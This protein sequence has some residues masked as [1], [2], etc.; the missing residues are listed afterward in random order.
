[1]G[2][3]QNL[4]NIDKLENER[5]KFSKYILGLFNFLHLERLSILDIKTL[6][7]RRIKADLVY[8]YKMKINIQYSRVNC[9]KYFFYE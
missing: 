5:C 2:N 9:R 6:E 3:P 4:A 7:D 1:M 8:L